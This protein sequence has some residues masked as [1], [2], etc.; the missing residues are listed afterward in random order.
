MLSG[1]TAANY[2]MVEIACFFVSRASEPLPIYDVG[3]AHG[4]RLLQIGIDFSLRAPVGAALAGRGLQAPAPATQWRDRACGDALRRRA[5]FVD[6][7]VVTPLR[8][9]PFDDDAFD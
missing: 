6:M 9:L 2:I 3:G 8:T 7:R 5:R 1:V 4:E